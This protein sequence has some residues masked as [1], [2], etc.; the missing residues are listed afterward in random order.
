MAMAQ[1]ST[2]DEWVNKLYIYNQKSLKEKK[3]L[4][5]AA[6]WMTFDF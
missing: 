4:T 6:T 2:N 5:Q 1:M 3:S